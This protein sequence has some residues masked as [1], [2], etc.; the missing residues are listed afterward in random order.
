MFTRVARFSAVLCLLSLFPITNSFAETDPFPG[1]ALGAEVGP[2]QAVSPS[3]GMPLDGSPGISCQAGAGLSGVADYLIGNYQVCVKTWRPQT[4]VQ[5]DANFRAAQDAAVATATAESQA[6]AIAHP[7]LQKCIQWG[8]IVHANGISTASGGVCANPVGSP[9]VPGVDT[10]TQSLVE[11]STTQS[12]PIASDT[13]TQQNTPAPV[14][15]GH[16]GYA[17]VHPDGHVCGVIVANS[18]DP[19]NNGGVMPQEYM[20]CPSGSRIVFQTTP[21][22]SGNV[23]GYSGSNVKYQNNE[24]VISNQDTSTLGIQLTIKNGIATDATGNS[25]LTGNGPSAT[26]PGSE[27]NT[28][29]TETNTASLVSP[30]LDTQTVRTL[31]LKS[32]LGVLT[33]SLKT[34]DLTSEEQSMIIKL[35]N[36]LKMFK[37]VSNLKKLVLSDITNSRVDVST[38]SKS[39]CT[40]KG[41]QIVPK[42][43]GSCVLQYAYTSDSGTLLTTTK[44]LIFKK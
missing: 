32:S 44:T 18:N 33:N 2:R 8:P 9:T 35:A 29:Q 27:S 40:I 37:T 43:A 22:S 15:G 10:S 20:G 25:W 5:A 11:T 36:N 14:T 6:W 7:G 28:V 26:L 39:V 12:Q 1:I 30:A 4:D 13:S 41:N 3:T 16:G 31:N 42:R 19:F 38:P 23:A 34:F 21:S 24:F 17:V